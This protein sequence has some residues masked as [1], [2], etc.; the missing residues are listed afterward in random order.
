MSVPVM[1][2]NVASNPS[3]DELRALG[4][5]CD[6][7]GLSRDPLLCDCRRL[8]H[9]SLSTRPVT[10]PT[11]M[12]NVTS[13]LLTS[14]SALVPEKRLTMETLS[15]YGVE[16]T[17]GPEEVAINHAT[18]EQE[19]FDHRTDWFLIV[20]AILLESRSSLVVSLFGLMSAYL[21]FAV[22]MRQLWN[23]EDLHR[24]LRE[25]GVLPADLSRL[26]TAIHKSRDE[27]PW[28]LKW[29][30]SS[31]AFA[32]IIPLGTALTWF[33]FVI[34]DI[35]VRLPVWRGIPLGSLLPSAP[36]AESIMAAVL[37]AVV[38]PTL[39]M[40]VWYWRK[41]P[42]ITTRQGA[43]KPRHGLAKTLRAEIDNDKPI[44][45]TPSGAC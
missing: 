33:A 4:F 37:M 18:H 8:R 17:I 2:L 3:L 34:A 30:R 20:H 16:R 12:S 28:W 1:R 6:H 44:E 7:F 36:L 15:D 35:E 32:A 22:A 5:W 40:L 23:G 21:W 9:Y 45:Q 42:R 13:V 25:R 26:F 10:E 31:P 19:I 39:L 29:A 24:A 38:L 43:R 27:Q 11:L 41:S 14:D